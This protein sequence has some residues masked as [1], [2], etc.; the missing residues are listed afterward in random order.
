VAVRSGEVYTEGRSVS[1]SGGSFTDTF[2]RWGVHVYH[3]RNEPPPPPAPPPPASPPPAPQ[4][5]PPAPAPT[6]TSTAAPVARLARASVTTV[7]RSPRAG[8]L[9][10][11]RVRA[12]ATTG[13]P[14]GTGAV[15]CTAR[16]GKTVLRPLSR[17]LRAGYAV[18]AW[19]LPKAARGKRLRVAV[20]VS[21]GGGKVTRTLSKRVS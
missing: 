2:E 17:R 20:V 9:Y 4:A 8:R 5:P 16:L 19:K 1:V 21:S 15:R 12:L 11:V 3:F 7:P 10:T 14:V 6:A 13:S 18:C